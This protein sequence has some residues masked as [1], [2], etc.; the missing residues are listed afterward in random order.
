MQLAK[1]YIKRAQKNKIEAILG[2]IERKEKAMSKE[3][4]QKHIGPSDWLGF[5]KIK[6]ILVIY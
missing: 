2:L 5:L 4:L 6:P 1:D 3:Q